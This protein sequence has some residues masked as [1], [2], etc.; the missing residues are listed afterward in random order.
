M[1]IRWFTLGKALEDATTLSKKT[2]GIT[3]LSIVGLFVTQLTKDEK[4]PRFIA[5]LFFHP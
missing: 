1:P 4:Q 3:T 2:F 5:W